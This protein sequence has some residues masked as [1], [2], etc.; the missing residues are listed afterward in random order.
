METLERG[1]APA[2]QEFGR[3]DLKIPEPIVFANGIKVYRVAGGVEE[4][5][6]L[7][8]V[9]GA[10]KVH[11]PKP[12]VAGLT[13][14]MLREGTASKDSK[15]I[16]E[17]IDQFGASISVGSSMDHSSLTLVC[18]SRYVDDLLPIVW[19]ILN[20]PTFPE[21][22]LQTITQNAI[23]GLRVKNEKIDYRAKKLFSQALFGQSHPYG[24]YVAESDYQQIEP[25]D[26][27]AFHRSAY[28]SANARIF[29]S[30]HVSDEVI[31]KVENRFGTSTW[32]NVSDQIEADH[33]FQ[34]DANQAHDIAHKDSVQ[35]AIR[36]GERTINKL[37]PD[38]AGFTVVNTV[39]GGYFSS[40]LMS[41]IRQEKG[42]TYGIYSSV[43][44]M[45]D[46]GVF[47]ISAEVNHENR[48]QA[49]TEIYKE[50]ERLQGEPVPEEELSLVRNYMLGSMLGSI[51]GPFKTIDTVKGLILYDLGIDYFYNY[52]EE[53]QAITPER[54]QELANKYLSRKTMYE[55]VVG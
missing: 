6:R 48:N 35:S 32:G 37:D 2:I 21:S 26:L 7:E 49:L 30:G 27:A 50:M 24:H 45:K 43:S 23:Q 22:E 19:D 53:V 15:Q 40:R 54:V 9:F 46:S 4:L 52:L 31:Q 28:G 17:E 3:P 14:S 47:Y 16:A 34:P 25:A 41:N 51:D 18:L 33:S 8:I 5:V 36:I 10:G 12:L 20:E 38:F 13:A 44:S 55:V 29:L 42:L 39:L 1:Q 11:Q